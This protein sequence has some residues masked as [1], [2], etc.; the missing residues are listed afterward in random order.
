MITEI[1]EVIDVSE[2]KIIIKLSRKPMCTNCKLDSMCHKD[3][4]DLVTIKNSGL[5][6]KKGDKIE[7]GIAGKKSLA[8]SCAI[9]LIP[10]VIFIVILASFRHLGELTSFAIAV[11][12]LFCYYLAVRIVIKKIPRYFDV[13][14]IRKL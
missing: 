13:T 1:V 4:D 7:V 10:V 3:D 14:I 8:I 12:A 9:F 11:S 6:L 5:L 2:D